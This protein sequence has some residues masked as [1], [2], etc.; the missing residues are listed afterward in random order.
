MI[1]KSTDIPH[2]VM[3]F[4]DECFFDFVKVFAG[5]KLAALLK[6]QDISNVNCLLACNDPFEILSYDSDDL[7]DLKKKTSIK[8]NSNSFVVLRGIKSKMMLLKNALTKKR[9]EL[10]KQTTKIS[11]NIMMTNNTASISL[12][13]D[14][15]TN[16]TCSSEQE[17]ANNSSS[18]G[19]TSNFEENV[20]KHLIKLLNE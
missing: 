2:N 10:K 4:E 16:S 7:L 20:K 6:F 18:S 17:L 8:L 11:S 5:D 19:T 12:I 1:S 13:I 14:H 3:E 9:N 15:S